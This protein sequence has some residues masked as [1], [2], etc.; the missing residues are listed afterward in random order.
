MPFGY[1]KDY[2]PPASG[3]GSKLS[4]K[5]RRFAEAYVLHHDAYQ[6]VLDAGYKT[7]NLKEMSRALLAHPL[8][9]TFIEEAQVAKQKRN[10]LSQ[11][12][13]IQKLIDI[14]EATEEESPQSALRGLELLGKHL[15]LYKDRTEIS[16]PD[17]EAIRMEQKVKQNA[18]DFASKLSRLAASG[19]T[20][21]VVGF[22]KR[23]G[24][25]GA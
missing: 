22:P 13:V 12:Y 20:P 18:A 3:R 14:V 23:S 24:D 11:D 8:V 17:G 25:G 1:K 19:E 21:G 5:Q 7:K 15:G 10:E 9:K 6:A 4:A 16:G 2:T